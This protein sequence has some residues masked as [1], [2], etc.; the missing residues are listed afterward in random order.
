M[1]NLMLLI[2]AGAR[3]VSAIAFVMV[4]AVVLLSPARGEA[5]EPVHLEFFKRSGC[6]HCASASEFLGELSGRHPDLKISVHDVADPVSRGRLEELCEEYNVKTPGV[7]AFHVRGR[8]LVG[9]SSDSSTGVQI[10]EIVKAAGSPTTLEGD[11]STRFD[12]VRIP[13]LGPVRLDD[14]GLTAFTIALGFIDGLNP[15]ATWMLLFLLGILVNLKSRSKMLIIGG[16]FVGTSGLVY[17][18]FM[19][20]WLNLFLVLG[21]SRIITVLLGLLAVFVGV[22]NVKDFFAFQRGISLSI[23][24]SAKPGIYAR[25]RKVISAEHLSGAITSVIA[26]AILVNLVELLCTAGLPAVY[27]SVLTAQDLPAW[28]YYA[29]LLL[30]VVAYMVD[31]AI[32]LGIA[33]VTLSRHKLQE[34]GARVLKLLSGS[35][36]LLLGLVLL[37]RPQWLVW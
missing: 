37:L 33:V 9:F 4:V 35:V 16:I 20:A 6:V 21:V 3:R 5:A 22:V 34:R 10:E 18:A 29:H 36:M 19:A 11:S 12:E 27:T 15:C 17:F 23:P 28:Q 7:P 2:V 31:D 8:F 14:F 25:A 32:L 30:Y 26:L 13:I 24:D 1:M